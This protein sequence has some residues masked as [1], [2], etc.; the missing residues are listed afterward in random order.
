MNQNGHNVKNLKPPESRTLV[1]ESSYLSPRK[2]LVEVLRSSVAG[3]AGRLSMLIELEALRR[4]GEGRGEERLRCSSARG[5]LAGEG[6]TGVLEESFIERRCSDCDNATAC[7]LLLLVF[8][9]EAGAEPVFGN[10]I[11]FVLTNCVCYEQVV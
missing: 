3:E 5:D 9:V 8:A 1:F 2:E 11:F 10:D 4:L 6:R 7:E